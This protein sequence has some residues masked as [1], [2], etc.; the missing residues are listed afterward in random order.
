[1]GRRCWRGW[2]KGSVWGQRSFRVDSLTSNRLMR[3]KTLVILGI[4]TEVIPVK[5]IHKIV[6]GNATFGTEG[7]QFSRVC[8]VKFGGRGDTIEL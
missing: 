1:M 3:P 6:F 4:G 7:L 5:E 8:A 2:W